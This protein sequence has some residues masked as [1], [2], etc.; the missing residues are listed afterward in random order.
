MLLTVFF[1][2]IRPLKKQPAKYQSVVYPQLFLLD[3]DQTFQRV[4]DPDQTLNNTNNNSS[5]IL[6]ILMVI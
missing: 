3:T 2:R 5:F 6:N 1:L 4:L